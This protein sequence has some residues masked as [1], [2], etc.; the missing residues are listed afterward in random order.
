MAFAILIFSEGFGQRNLSA[1]KIGRNQ[2]SKNNIAWV[3][4]GP[5]Y[6]QLIIITTFLLK[7]WQN[8]ED[9]P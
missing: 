4:V 8:K 7:Q 3:K 1:I 9:A 5:W 2:N 6:L